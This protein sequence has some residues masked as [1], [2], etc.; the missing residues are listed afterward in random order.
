MGEFQ[1]RGRSD[2]FR[3]FGSKITQKNN[4]AASLTSIVES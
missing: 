2:F 1:I 3:N 4:E